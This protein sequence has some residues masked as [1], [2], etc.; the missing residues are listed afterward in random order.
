V[1]AHLSSVSLN[2]VQLHFSNRRFFQRHLE[3]F[4]SKMILK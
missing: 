3:I 2:L 1:F 4:G